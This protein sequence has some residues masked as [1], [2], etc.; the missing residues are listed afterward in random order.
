MAAHNIFLDKE[1]FMEPIISNNKYSYSF[2]PALQILEVFY[3]GQII[4]KRNASSGNAF[5]LLNSNDSI[6]KVV[7]MPLPKKNHHLI[8]WLLSFRKGRRVFIQNNLSLVVPE[9]VKDCTIVNFIYGK[10]FEIIL[11]KQA[12]TGTIVRLAAY[13]DANIAK[14][15]ILDL[16]TKYAKFHW[17]HYPKTFVEK[18]LADRF[19]IT[20]EELKST[21]ITFI[22][23]TL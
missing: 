20:P 2:N 13:I 23:T 3:N 15:D 1:A 17:L 19:S 14:T 9:E 8:M 16:L 18:V 12:E 21:G 7:T 6:Q 4:H 10:N 5:V 22:D 11:G